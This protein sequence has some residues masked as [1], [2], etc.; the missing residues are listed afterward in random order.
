L[1]KLIKNGRHIDYLRM[2]IL[3]WLSMM[4]EVHVYDTRV[5]M[6]ILKGV[7]GDNP[8]YNV[9]LKGVKEINPIMPPSILLNVHKYSEPISIRVIVHNLQRTHT[10]NVIIKFKHDNIVRQVT[11]IAV[12]HKLY[13]ISLSCEKGSIPDTMSQKS[14]IYILCIQYFKYPPDCKFYILLPLSFPHRILPSD[15]LYSILFHT[16]YTCT[17]ESIE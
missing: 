7:K 9:I 15:I 6:I 16:I 13:I 4:Q 8:L 5:I 17:S 11:I 12:Q 1:L 14:Q 2:S 3:V 10:A